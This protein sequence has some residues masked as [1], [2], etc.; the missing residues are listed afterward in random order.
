MEREGSRSRGVLGGNRA[1]TWKDD[2]PQTFFL[3]NGKQQVNRNQIENNPTNPKYAHILRTFSVGS[4]NLVAPIKIVGNTT[5]GTGIT[6]IING[7]IQLGAKKTSEP[8][9]AKKTK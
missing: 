6:G 1:V 2:A 3:N 8:A 4:D 7:Q 5:D 9:T